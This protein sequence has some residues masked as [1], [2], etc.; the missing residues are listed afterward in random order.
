MGASVQEIRSKRRARRSKRLGLR[1]PVL[2]YGQ[3]TCGQPFHELTHTVEINA[4]GALILLDAFVQERQTILLENLN[5]QLDEE[6]RV[7]NV[8][9]LAN[10][11][12]VVGIEFKQMAGGFWEIYLH[13]PDER[14]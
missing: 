10:G 3:D 2:V 8:R 11:R 13:R 5:T 14:F 6:C 7:V 1:V 12:W 4:N 9:S